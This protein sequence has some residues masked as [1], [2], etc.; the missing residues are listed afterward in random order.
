MKSYKEEAFKKSLNAEL[1]EQAIPIQQ[2][3]YTS[4]FEPF[5]HIGISSDKRQSFQASIAHSGNGRP[6]TSKSIGK[7][8]AAC[9]SAHS[10]WIHSIQTTRNNSSATTSA[11]LLAIRSIKS[12]NNNRIPREYTMIQRGAPLTAAGLLGCNAVQGQEG[13]KNSTFDR[14]NKKSVRLHCIVD[15]LTA[16]AATCRNVPELTMKETTIG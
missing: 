13:G 3:V 8:C 7:A 4:G 12:W 15:V 10:G 5:G 16:S 11:A 14:A 1:Q 2:E 9:R 6:R